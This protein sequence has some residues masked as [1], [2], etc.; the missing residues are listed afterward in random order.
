MT[1]YIEFENE[2]K[3]LEEQLQEHKE[4]QQQVF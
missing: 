3:I 1:N 2:I 4:A